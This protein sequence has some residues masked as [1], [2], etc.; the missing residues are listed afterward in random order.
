MN[1]HLLARSAYASAATPTRTTRGTEYEIFARVTHRLKAA[2]RGDGDFIALAGALHD[3]RTLWTALAADV[4]LET[5]A[6]PKSLRAQIFY[7]SEFTTQHTRRILAGEAGADVL[8]DINTAMMRGLRN[9]GDP[10]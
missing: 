10:A 9:E 8:I 3:N 6:L 7:L 2:G 5:N 1:A 4:A